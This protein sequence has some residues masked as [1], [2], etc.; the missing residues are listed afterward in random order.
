MEKWYQSGASIFLICWIDQS[1]GEGRCVTGFAGMMVLICLTFRKDTDLGMQG[2]CVWKLGLCASAGV[3]DD[4]V[5]LK[6]PVFHLRKRVYAAKEKRNEGHKAN[7]AITSGPSVS[8]SEN[9]EN[10]PG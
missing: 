9:W 8:S 1:S 4:Y 5:E 3:G 2:E 7:I 6:N 10:G